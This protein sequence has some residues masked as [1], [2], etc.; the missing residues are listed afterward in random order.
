MTTAVALG[1]TV[2]VVTGAIVGAMVRTR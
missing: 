1:N 2:E